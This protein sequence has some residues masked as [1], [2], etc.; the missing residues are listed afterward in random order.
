LSDQIA[1]VEKYFGNDVVAQRSPAMMSNIEDMVVATSQPD[2]RID[3]WVFRE[4]GLAALGDARFTARA[5]RLASDCAA[6]P[7]L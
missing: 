4:L 1:Q 7:D 3:S 6:H 5:L 2:H